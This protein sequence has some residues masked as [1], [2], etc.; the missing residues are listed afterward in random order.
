[1]TNCKYEPPSRLLA[2][3][4][5]T[6]VGARKSRP[7]GVF[8][9]V[10]RHL[11]RRTAGAVALAF[12]VVTVVLALVFSVSMRNDTLDVQRHDVDAVL[13]EKPRDATSPRSRRHCPWR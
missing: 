5:E 1:M 8:A 10:E 12:S 3:C 11:P 13:A 2:E 9:L 4:L 7:C 6:C